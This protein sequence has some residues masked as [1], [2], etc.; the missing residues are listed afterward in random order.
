MLSKYKLVIILLIGIIP[1]VSFSQSVPYFKSKGILDSLETKFRKKYTL[2]DY[3]I[4][5]TDPKTKKELVVKTHYFQNTK[6]VKCPLLILVPPIKGVSMREK[7]VAKHFIEKG[8]H[9][10]VIEPI[11]NISDYTI[12]ISEFENNLLSF[13]GAV[14]SVI[15]VMEMRPEIQ[16]ENMFLWGSSMGAIYSSIVI[17]E[18]DRLNASALILGGAPIADVVTESNQKY[19]VNYRNERMKQENLSSLEEFRAKMKE[20]M[21]ID[22][23]ILAENSDSVKVYICIATK[24]KTVPTKYQRQLL[25]AFDVGTDYNDYKMGHATLLMQS[26]LFQISE[27]S[28]FFGRNMKK[29]VN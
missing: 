13:V 23:L 1:M 5:V 10:I 3:S 22:P 18:D 15:D 21:T 7:K 20:N 14:R 26:H 6:E 29:A 12:P 2:I 28:N 8:Y 16:N 9:V 17:C 24:D 19:I 4:K 11:K 27:Y 25:K